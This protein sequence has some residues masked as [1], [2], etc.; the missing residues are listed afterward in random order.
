LWEDQLL[1]RARTP[2]PTA[3]GATAICLARPDACVGGACRPG[4][5]LKLTVCSNCGPAASLRAA[6]LRQYRSRAPAYR[7]RLPGGRLQLSAPDTSQATACRVT[8]MTVD[9]HLIAYYLEGPVER[10]VVGHGGRAWVGRGTPSSVARP[11]A[12]SGS[13]TPAGS[14]APAFGSTRRCRFD[15]DPRPS[16]FIRPRH[17]VDWAAHGHQARSSA[18]DARRPPP[19]AE[20]CGRVV[21]SGVSAADRGGGH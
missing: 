11:G 9:H 10:T 2:P 18:R 12:V 5:P 4:A 20:P 15:G 16:D 17:R 21:V 6:E 13:T 7:R 3:G 1:E 14:T 8:D 19:S